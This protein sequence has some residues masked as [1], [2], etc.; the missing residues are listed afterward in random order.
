MRDAVAEDFRQLPGVEVL[1]LDGVDGDL[2]RRE[3]RKAIGRADYTLLIAPEAELIL[4]ERCTWAPSR[5]LLGPTLEAIRLT[6][7]KLALGSWWERHGVPTPKTGLARDWPP[8]RVPAVIKPADGA[9]SMA[10]YYCGN[11]SAFLVSRDAAFGESQGDPI[12][13]DF[14]PGRPASVAFLIGPTQTV[15]LLPTFQ[16]LSDDGRFR[17]EGGELPTSP[18]LAE[19]AISLGQRAVGCVTGLLGYVGVDLVLGDEV[20]GSHDSAIEINPRLT[21][22]Y[23]GL[24]KLANFNLA[25]AMLRVANGDPVEPRWKPERVRFQP[26]GSVSADPTHGPGTA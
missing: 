7:D 10:T 20:D 2:E 5:R 14:V 4:E 19:R 8:T 18:D 11:E 26:D 17:Y 24:R 9:G 15:P 6:R 16:I 25:D 21:T 12:A 23:V 3:F 1:S 22:S 13:Q